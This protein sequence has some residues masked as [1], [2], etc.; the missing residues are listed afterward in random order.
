MSFS[1]LNADTQITIVQNNVEQLK[2]L[3]ISSVT[4]LQNQMKLQI[5]L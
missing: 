4:A 2:T 1:L 3:T 5:N